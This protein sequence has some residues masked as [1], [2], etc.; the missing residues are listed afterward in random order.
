MEI[1]TLPGHGGRV[2][3]LSPSEP[4]PMTAA[5]LPP[6]LLALAG[7]EIAPPRLA[8]ATLVLIDLQYEYLDGPLALTGVGAAL[9]RASALLAAVRA[10]G[11]RVVHVAH[12][13]RPG[14]PFDRAVRR[15]AIV[16]AVAPRPGEPVVEKRAVSAFLDT[17]LATRLPEPGAAPLIVAGFMTHNCVSSF[18]RDAGDGGHAITVAHD[19]CA[20]RPLPGPAGIVID[21]ADLHAASLA[22]LA[23][24]FARLASVAEILA[25]M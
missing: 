2:P 5:A 20:T 18:V 9:E 25:V 17:D 6:T 16:A 1:G 12:A 22:G 21:A 11:G 7:R 3:F 15:G 24:R 14:G 4:E 13:G 10:A 23:D 8:E 19:A